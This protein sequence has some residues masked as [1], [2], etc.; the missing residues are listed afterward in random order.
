MQFWENIFNGELYN[1]TTHALIS[2]VSFMV[3][4]RIIII[5]NQIGT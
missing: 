5:E 4:L 1:F 3:F 2:H